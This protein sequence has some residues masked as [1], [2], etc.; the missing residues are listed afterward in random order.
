[1]IL[2]QRGRACFVYPAGELVAL[3]TTLRAAG[4]EPK[5]LQLVHSLPGAPA[6]VVLVAAAAAKAGGLSVLPPLVERS[7]LA[8]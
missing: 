3:L 1:M 8:R 2:G 5:E 4:L 6:R 7:P